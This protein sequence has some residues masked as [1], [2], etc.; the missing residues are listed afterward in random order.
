MTLD[1]LNN[2]RCT[3]ASSDKKCLDPN[4]NCNCDSGESIWSD[5]SFVFVNQEHV[6]ITR[7]VMLRQDDGELQ[8]KGNSGGV[9]GNS[10]SQ[11]RFTLSDLKCYGTKE[12][13]NQHV[14]TFKTSDAYI[15][16]PGWRR[17]DISFSFRTAS[18]PPAIVLY[19]L[20]TSRN[21]GYFRLTLMTDSRL[22]FEYIVNRRPRKMFLTATHKLNNGE[23]QQVFI[24][25]DSSNLRLTVN[26]DSIFV[27]LDYNDH[28]G[29]FEGPLFIGGAPSK[30][31]VGDL[32]KRNGFTGCFKGLNINGR[33]IDLNDYLS[34]SMPTVISGCQPSC[35]KNLCQNGGKCIEYWGSYECECSNPIAH[36]GS[37]CEINLNT[38]SITF[39][40]P[41]SHYV[42]QSNETST[43]PPYLVKNILLNIRTYQES[44]LVLY[45]CDGLNNFI[46]L[47]KNGSTLVLS[48]NSN[49]TIIAVQVP[50]DEEYNSDIS[51]STASPTQPGPSVAPAILES[52]SP[53][54]A[55]KGSSNSTANRDPK[56]SRI[57]GQN[58]KAEYKFDRSLKVSNTSGSGQPI[59]I[60]IE[61]HRLR[62][63]FYVN[64]NFVVVEKP[65][66]FITNT[67]QHRWLNPDLELVQPSKSRNVHNFVPRLYLANIDDQFTTR[68]PGFTGCIQGLSID[69]QLFDF[70]RAH[71]TGELRG[72]YKIGCKMHC[73]SFPC[74]NQGTCIEN[75]RE[76]KIQ[77]KC[78][79]T[80]YVGRLCDEEI[81]A[82]FNGRT[83]HFVYNL[84]N[85]LQSSTVAQ[86]ETREKNVTDSTGASAT[87]TGNATLS[88][89]FSHTG[90]AT[91]N[92]RLDFLEVSFAFSTD[93]NQSFTEKSG[94]QVLILITKS[95]S[96]KHFF[97]GLTPDGGLMIQEDYGNSM[98]EYIFLPKF[99]Y[100]KIL[101]AHLSN[102]LNI[103]L[104]HCR[105]WL[106]DQTSLSMMGTV[107]WSNIPGLIK[108]YR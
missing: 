90:T 97:I 60:K 96:S 35:T 52:P 21:H 1:G 105:G 34:P 23:W 76:D 70:N 14:I 56:A 12:F 36:S 101:S 22:L 71:L 27:D 57:A 5:D 89:D 103:L 24:E 39:V 91:V 82:V 41:E 63:T 10:E 49:S 13:G 43:Y 59:Q 68:L 107:T 9:I 72:D 78:D 93:A 87:R 80:S 50:I 42:E 102:Y 88:K 92:E 74:K 33:S 3:C 62:T 46:Q 48:Y 73:D 29:T 65:M 8:E 15:E 79:T 100:R 83:S 104:Q 37:N 51:L 7:I 84:S 85:K 4:K 44:S 19:Q 6:G 64:N 25:Y 53:S 108:I 106:K 28:L 69:N 45:A 95:N 31:L 18:N 77:C 98:C 54:A 20:A 61:R 32:S 2:G 38:N 47:H 75:W 26:D 55:H 40:T 99:Q 58:N 94:L 17:G 86:I 66:I 16:V 67:S 11:S 81:A 30:Y